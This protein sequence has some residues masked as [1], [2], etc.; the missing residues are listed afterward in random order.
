LA[1]TLNPERL[2]NLTS[3][4]AIKAIGCDDCSVRPIKQQFIN[5]P[6]GSAELECSAVNSIGNNCHS[7]RLTLTI[8]S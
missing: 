2:V 8:N 4:E 7:G 5:M 3:E 6:D 1:G